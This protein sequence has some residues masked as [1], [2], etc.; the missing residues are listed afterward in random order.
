MSATVAN[1]YLRTSLRDALDSGDAATE[2][3]EH[4]R[5]S[6]AYLATLEPEVRAIV[7]ECYAKSTRGAFVL[8]ACLVAGA[9]VSAWFVKEKALGK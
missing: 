5:E 9:A 2:I 3:A 4:V 6:L 7:R 1:Q 8:E